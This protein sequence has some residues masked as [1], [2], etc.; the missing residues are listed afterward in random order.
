MQLAAAVLVHHGLFRHIVGFQEGIPK[1]FIVFSKLRYPIHSWLLADLATIDR[2]VSTFRSVFSW[3]FCLYGISGV[4]RL[5]DLWPAMQTMASV[6]AAVGGDLE[7]MCVLNPDPYN[8]RTISICLADLAARHGH[9]QILRH[10]LDKGHMCSCR[11]LDWAATNGHIEVVHFL[12]ELYPQEGGASTDAMDGAA[13]NGHLDI[14]HFLHDNRQEGCT[15]AALNLAARHGHFQVVEFLH[16]HRQEGGTTAAMDSAAKYG[17]LDIVKFLH[18]HRNEGCTTKAMDGAI[19][20][21]HAQV[22]QFLHEYRTEGCTR[23][24]LDRLVRDNLFYYLH[25]PVVQFLLAHGYNL[26]HV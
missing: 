8:K 22:V 9:I 15:V 23:D 11:A 1:E 17:H 3:W 26:K 12:N 18:A 14:V 10:L 20:N 5:C 4:R 16:F 19:I 13:T 24:A 7:L 2:R 21:G 25:L 6:Y